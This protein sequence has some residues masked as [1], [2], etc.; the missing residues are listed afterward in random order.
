M[1]RRPPRSTL[2]PY[3][4]LFRSRHVPGVARAE[5]EMALVGAGAAAHADIHEQ[6]EGAILFEALAH[7][8]EY[9]FPPVFGKLPIQVGG[10]PLARVGQSEVL[11]VLGGAGMRVSAFAE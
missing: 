11:E 8:V 2:F 1:R 6:P 7:A 5:I 4:T 3:T 9:D 10:L